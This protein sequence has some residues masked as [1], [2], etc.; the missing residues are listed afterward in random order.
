MTRE[1]IMQKYAGI[2]V[3]SVQNPV[4]YAVSP[5]MLEEQ[6]AQIEAAKVAQK[7][8]TDALAQAANLTED[9]GS[10]VRAV[11]NPTSL[12]PYAQQITDMEKAYAQQKAFN[13]EKDR[14]RAAMW[15][16]RAQND[17]FRAAGLPNRVS[18]KTI[19]VSND[20]LAAYRQAMAQGSTTQNVTPTP[21][22]STQSSNTS[23]TIVEE[24]LTPTIQ[25]E[26]APVESSTAQVTTTEQ[27]PKVSRQSAPPKVAT[28]KGEASTV[29]DATVSNATT[30]AQ[31]VPVVETPSTATPVMTQATTVAPTSA[32]VSTQLNPV[33]ASVVSPQSTSGYVEPLAYYNHKTAYG[34]GAMPTFRQSG[35]PMNFSTNK[36]HNNGSDPQLSSWAGLNKSYDQLDPVARM[37]A[38]DF[39]RKERTSNTQMLGATIN[40]DLAQAL[41]SPQVAQDV[42]QRMLQG[43]GLQEALSGAM[44]NYNLQ[45]G[46]FGAFNTGLQHYVPA[47]GQRINNLVNYAINSGVDVPEFAQGQF[48]VTAPVAYRTVGDN[49]EITLSSGQKLTLPKENAQSALSTMVGNAPSA[50]PA[51]STKSGALTYEQRV[52]LEKQKAQQRL[53]ELDVKAKQKQISAAEAHEYKVLLK[54]LGLDNSK[55]L[56]DYKQASKAAENTVID[57]GN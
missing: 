45:N 27:S 23:P 8:R 39:I 31:A 46:Q 53:V 4:T 42:Q 5:Q 14:E 32:P 57:T 22:S 40:N 6:R 51:S 38:D 24:V 29:V 15:L 48:G 50:A 2:S 3:P 54:Q 21:A 19:P 1:E 11:L 49:V 55:E 47:A 34:N 52:A 37:F 28:N 16:A 10:M 30:P 35:L 36:F 9:Y 20:Q 12:D 13:D 41:N 25:A 44:A 33:V 43:Q 56:Y 17:Q 18:Y 7:Q 26:S